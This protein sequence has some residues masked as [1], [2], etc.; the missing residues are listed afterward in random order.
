MRIG[1]AIATFNE[2][3]D[4]DATVALCRASRPAASRVTVVDDCSAVIPFG[5]KRHPAQ[6]VRLIVNPRQ[7][8]TSRSK[9]LA[10]NE[11]ASYCD[12]VVILDAHMRMPDDWLQQIEGVL[13][14]HPRAI[15]CA[16]CRGFESH[17]AFAGSGGRFSDRLIAPEPVWLPRGEAEIERCPALLGACYFM[18][19]ETWRAIGG[20]N[21]VAYGWGG[22]ELDL[23]MRAWLCNREIVR[24]N[25][26]VVQHRFKRNVPESL[27][28]WH[29]Q[30]NS[31]AICYTLFGQRVWEES[32]EA[33]MFAQYDPQAIRHF[34]N[35]L[36][37]LDLERH[38]FNL[39]RVLPDLP[40]AAGWTHPRGVAAQLKADASRPKITEVTVT[41]PGLRNNPLPELISKFFVD[42]CTDEVV[43]QWG[44]S[45]LSPK[46]RSAAKSFRVVDH[47]RDQCMAMMNGVM[48]VPVA[49]VDLFGDNPLH[50]YVTAGLT[51]GEVFSRVIV[52]GAMQEACIRGLE[53]SQ[54]I[55]NGTAIYVLS[56]SR[57][58]NNRFNWVQVYS[59][60][61]KGERTR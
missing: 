54:A 38:A 3:P 7:V 36:P 40:E 1:V 5:G 21:P 45:E 22:D 8:G 2:G 55:T 35:S 20:M 51:S 34:K 18:T 4:L 23:S 57:P 31:M 60:A 24:C 58:I 47:D 15:G 28:T 16:A 17:G 29:V 9:A 10:V 59:G 48:F 27:N 46:L 6:D 30:Y 14:K 42:A 25:K 52:S 56:Q 61:W 49:E 12:A 44:V 43:L 39:V 53:D 50:T 26:L 13:D 11:L 32:Y 33:P 37:L 19:V 41:R